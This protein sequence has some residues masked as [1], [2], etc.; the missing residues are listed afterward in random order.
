MIKG[1]AHVAIAV[2]DLLAA[3]QRYQAL[4]DLADQQHRLPSDTPQAGPTVTP[5]LVRGQGVQVVFLP[6]GNSAIELITPVNTSGPVARFLQRQGEGVHHLCLQVAD[7]DAA[8]DHLKQQGFETVGEIGEAEG[9][10][11]AFLHPRST[12]G[13][14]IELRQPRSA[15][16]RT[17]A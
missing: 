7:L 14:L 15:E 17:N 1:I 16:E 13:V 2:K 12:H 10:R 6:V 3:A 5:E 8:L 4:L 9:R 11:F